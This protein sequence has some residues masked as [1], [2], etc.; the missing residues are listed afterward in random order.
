MA[1]RATGFGTGGT[2]VAVLVGV[3]IGQTATTSKNYWSQ[4]GIIAALVIG[5][6]LVTIGL[7]ALGSVYLGWWWPPT[8]EERVAV[9]AQ[10]EHDEYV[11]R[12][13]WQDAIQE[14]IDELHHQSRD[15]SNELRNDDTFGMLHP[16]SAWSKNRHVLRD[17]QDVRLLVRDAYEKTNAINERTK[18]RWEAASHEQANDPEWRKLTEDEKQESLEALDA[19]EKASAALAEIQMTPPTPDRNPPKTKEEK[20]RELGELIHEGEDLQATLT[21]P[22]QPSDRNVIKSRLY[23]LPRVVKWDKRTWRWFEVN[24]PESL[25]YL[26]RYKDNPR[27]EPSIRAM[28]KFVARR[29]EALRK[30]LDRL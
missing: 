26:T 27:E 8:H 30:V 20:L 14:L 28:P 16:A 4:P 9:R 3:L 7:W 11:A 21:D 5:G 2:G 6:I 25:G 22:T 10:R 13:T 23:D 29:I 24:S 1:T 18:E 15:L 17:H 19:V 12:I